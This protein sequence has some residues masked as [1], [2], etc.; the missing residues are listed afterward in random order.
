MDKKIPNDN[1]S[2]KE[3]LLKWMESVKKERL[4]NPEAFIDREPGFYVGGLKVMPGDT[5]V[6][7]NHGL[8]HIIRAGCC[9]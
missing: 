8:P 4:H 3:Y 6:T 5:F 9:E 2:A 7:D 1:S